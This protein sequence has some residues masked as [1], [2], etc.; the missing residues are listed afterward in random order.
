MGKPH[1]ELQKLILQFLY[2]TYFYLDNS[3]KHL[4]ASSAIDL[5]PS[6]GSCIYFVVKAGTRGTSL[7]GKATIS[8]D[9][10]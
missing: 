7:A 4:I 2:F 1:L 9:S 8:S 10:H 3:D 6:D 5:V